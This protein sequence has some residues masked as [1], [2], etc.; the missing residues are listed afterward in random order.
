[1]RSPG[2]GLRVGAII[3]E[4]LRRY[5]SKEQAQSQDNDVVWRFS[6]RHH[7]WDYSP[8]DQKLNQRYVTKQCTYRTVKGARPAKH[9]VEICTAPFLILRRKSQ[10]RC[11]DHFVIG[12]E[13]EA[14]V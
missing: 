2:P 7:S 14:S 3:I 11:A 6:G 9:V 1:M 10:E 4:R 8:L 13:L 12:D 5:T